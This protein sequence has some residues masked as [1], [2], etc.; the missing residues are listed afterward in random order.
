MN[1]KIILTILIFS[2]SVAGLFLVF[3]FLV[4]LI[5]K[6]FHIHLY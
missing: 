6:I 3:S 1:W 4:R 5:E 2:V